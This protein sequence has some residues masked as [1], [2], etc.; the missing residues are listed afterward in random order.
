MTPKLVLTGTSERDVKILKYL[1]YKYLFDGEPVT[2]LKI[3]K[4]LYFVHVWYLVTFGKSCF[5]D[6]F[7]AWPLGPVL[8]TIY[9]QLAKYGSSPIDDEFM[10]QDEKELEDIKKEL[11][12]DLVQLIDEVY[13]KYG[14]L[15][16]FQLVN[17]THN[18]SPWLK[19]REGLSAT[20]KSN[21]VIDDTDVLAKYSGKKDGEKK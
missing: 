15:S 14:T 7:Q 6:K 19:A 12:S 2:N 3:Q 10:L 4:V 9:S 21:N 1:L 8:P 11:G 5:S 18:D 16:A 20:E 13:E 17:I